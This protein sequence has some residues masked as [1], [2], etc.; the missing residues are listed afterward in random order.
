MKKSNAQVNLLK[1]FGFCA[2]IFEIIVFMSD[3]EFEAL[4]EAGWIIKG[5]LIFSLMGIIL[6]SFTLAQILTQLDN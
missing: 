1:I 2:L 5:G 4:G 3:K 6:F